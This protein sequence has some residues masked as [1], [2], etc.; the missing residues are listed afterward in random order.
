MLFTPWRNEETDLKGKYTSYKDHYEALSDPIAE[1][2][3]QY[4]VC[5]EDL[6]EMQRL[7]YD[8]VEFDCIA[9]VTQHVELQDEDVAITKHYL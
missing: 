1:Q 8:D 9:P 6:N 7:D 3:K 2:M 5:A 4:A